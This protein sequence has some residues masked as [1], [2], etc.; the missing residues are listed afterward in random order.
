MKIKLY[1]QYDTEAQTTIA[2]KKAKIATAKINRSK[3]LSLSFNPANGSITE[4][5][6]SIGTDAG[7]TSKTNEP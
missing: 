7:K 3:S 6:D 1:W 5:D 2:I 4:D